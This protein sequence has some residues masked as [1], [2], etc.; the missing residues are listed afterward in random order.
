MRR[1]PGDRIRH[2]YDLEW[3]RNR[4]P[5]SLEWREME[6]APRVF[7]SNEQAIDLMIGNNMRQHVKEVLAAAERSHHDL[8]GADGCLFACLDGVTVRRLVESTNSHLREHTWQLTNDGEFMCF[9]AVIILRLVFQTT[10]HG[11]QE[12]VD[13]ATWCG[14]PTYTRYKQLSS[15]LRLHFAGTSNDRQ[16]RSSYMY[17]AVYEHAN[18]GV[19]GRHRTAYAMC[20]LLRGVFLRTRG[21]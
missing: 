18:L 3:S 7:L 17:H 15:C 14:A 21:G 20:A 12:H 10:Y 6:C 1:C 11:V 4:S 5:N 13:A 9:V 8:T 16:V 2:G 19:C